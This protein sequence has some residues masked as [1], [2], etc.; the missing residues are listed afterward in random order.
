[1][2]E[3]EVGKCE[4]CRKEENLVL[5]RTYFHYDI[6]CECHSPNHFE[7]VRHC[8]DCTPAEPVETKLYVK[9]IYLNRK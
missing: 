6:K 8:K 9:T 5:Q 2:G 1:M 3:Q 7:I 4:V